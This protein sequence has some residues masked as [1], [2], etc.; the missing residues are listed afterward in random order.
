MRFLRDAL[1]TV[2]ALAVGAAIIGFL[3]TRNGLSARTDPPAVEKAVAEHI[4]WLSIPSGAKKQVNPY[5]RDPKAW[6][7]G[8][9]HFQDHCAVCHDENGSGKS[10]IG[11]NVYPKVPDMRLAD[12]QDLSD[13]ALFFI[14]AN[15]VRYTAMPAWA[16]EHTPEE[17]WKLVSFIRKLPR[18]TPEELERVTAGGGQEHH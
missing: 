11:R 8:G 17:T 12:T 15:G 14:I 1:T 5:A 10:E 18:L 2:L 4:R 7:E 3:F 13:G 16:S 9:M 6:V